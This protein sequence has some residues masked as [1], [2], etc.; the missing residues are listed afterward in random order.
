MSEYSSHELAMQFREWILQHQNERYEIWETDDASQSIMLTTPYGQAVISFREFDIDV[1]EFTIQAANTDELKFYLHFEMRD[2]EHAKEL[3][4]EMV[5]SLLHLEE[6]HTL[7][8]LLCCTSALTTSYF[9]NNLQRT[10]DTLNLDMVFHAVSFNKLMEVGPDY[11]IILMAPQIGYQLKS[12]SM[13]FKDK[14]VIQIPVSIF[15]EYDC[16]RLIELIRN[17]IQEEKEY[18]VPEE[19]PSI[20]VFNNKKKL[21]VLIVICEYNQKRIIYRLV[22]QGR[23]KKETTIIKAKYSLTDLED[24]LDVELKREPDIDAVCISTPGVLDKG[25]LTFREPGIY[26]AEVLKTF[27]ERYQKPFYFYNDANT[28]VVG[29]Y[30]LQDSYENISFYFHP[31]SARNSGVGHVINGKLHS[32]RNNIAGEMQYLANTLKFKYRP[33]EIVKTQE[34][35]LNLVSRFLTAIISCVDPE[36][37]AICCDMFSDTEDLR[38]ELAKTFQEEFIPD[39]ILVNDPTEYMFL[40]CIYLALQEMEEENQ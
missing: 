5:Q 34:G 38:K 21:A 14:K 32:G 1:I 25:K 22:D 24:L 8:V 16:I 17:T 18:E 31:R 36:A 3:Y 30:A 2:L 27:T 19:L 26:N 37:I 23:I 7:H 28:M 29:F 12:I 9:A 6:T 40:G 15:A 10:A 20:H 39:L 33:E 11:D 4:D 13:A 35:F